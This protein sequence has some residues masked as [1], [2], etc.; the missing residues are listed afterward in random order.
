YLLQLQLPTATTHIY[1]NYYNPLV[2]LS[3]SAELQL[4]NTRVEAQRQI[5]CNEVTSRLFRCHRVV[6]R[7]RSNFTKVSQRIE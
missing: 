1:C 6:P 4:L 7:L 2:Q 5:R 3:S